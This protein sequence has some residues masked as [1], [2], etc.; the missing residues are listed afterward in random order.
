MHAEYSP[1]S[2]K[3]LASDVAILRGDLKANCNNKVAAN[4]RELFDLSTKLR[5]ALIQ[6]GENDE[7]MPPQ[8]RTA[9]YPCVIL[10]KTNSDSLKFSCLQFGAFDVNII[11]SKEEKGTSSTQIFGD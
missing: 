11:Y 9:E 4:I 1:E 8:N 2:T 7:P 5:T 3:Q 6:G 10:D